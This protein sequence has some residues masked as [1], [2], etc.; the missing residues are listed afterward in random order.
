MKQRIT[1]VKSPSWFQQHLD[2]WWLLVLLAMGWILFD[3]QR[4]YWDGAFAPLGL[5][6]VVLVTGA[7]GVFMRLLALC[8][9][10]SITKDLA[11]R[12]FLTISLAV[13]AVYSCAVLMA[14]SHLPAE[15]KLLYLSL[16]LLTYS[17]G[18]ARF[19]THL[20]EWSVWVHP[21]F[22]PV[23][24]A[25]VWVDELGWSSV[26]VLWLSLAMIILHKE[27][28]LHS[29]GFAISVAKVNQELRDELEKANAQLEKTSQ[30]KTQVLA[31]ASHDLRQP[32]H[33]LGLMMDEILDKSKNDPS[34]ELLIQARGVV[35]SLSDSLGVLMSAARLDSGSLVVEIQDVKLERVMRRVAD[36]YEL[37]AATKG[38]E[39]VVNSGSAVIR[40][41]EVLLLNILSNLLS[42]AVR[43]TAHGRVVLGA[44]VAN[45]R[46]ILT[47]TDSGKGIAPERLPH[48]FEEHQR[49]GSED[50][51]AGGTG[52][53][54]SIV[55]KQ[56]ELLG[57]D[58]HI[59]SQPGCGTTFHVVVP[60]VTSP[61]T[62]DS[63][64][65]QSSDFPTEG[66]PLRVL[67]IDDDPVIAQGMEAMA[68]TQGW[69][70][71]IISDP[72]AW[73]TRP[74]VFEEAPDLLV[75]DFHLDCDMNGFDMV[76]SVRARFGPD[77]PVIL[78]TGDVDNE[79]ELRAAASHVTILHKPVRPIRLRD[80]IIRAALRYRSVRQGV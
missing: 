68:L 11:G 30:T 9:G 22:I 28:I 62:E 78:L 43:Y 10:R 35:V 21:A 46:A 51:R 37:L 42:N 77:F 26:F 8:G 53:G 3:V 69:L 65:V 29:V 19:A 48:I 47:V 33:S 39:F 2:W 5:T 74:L 63:E 79:L 4:P 50:R 38:L 56:C 80:A 20:R 7:P 76:E 36:E 58:I 16:S 57:H 64:E 67:V 41:D 66:G 1:L 24:I 44:Q 40:T 73:I 34:R 15:M 31:T 61:T 6:I 17:I 55:K 45:D 71:Q 52:L 49:L 14:L 18:I 60:V 54:L 12:P 72:P 70:P 27:S 75:T 25:V 13:S 32:V 59:E 23:F